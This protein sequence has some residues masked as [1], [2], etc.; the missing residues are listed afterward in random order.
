M[1]YVFLDYKLPNPYL[2][3]MHEGTLDSF[4]DCT[5]CGQSLSALL[6]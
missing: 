5:I 4:Y 1:H 2:G 6:K 3:Q